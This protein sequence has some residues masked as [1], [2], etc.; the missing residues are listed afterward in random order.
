MRKI[1]L[2]I[3]VGCLFLLSAAPALADVCKSDSCSK[4]EVGAFMQDIAAKCYNTG[5]CSLADIMIV[6]NNV[7]IYVLGII[8]SLVLLMYVIGGIMMLT[9]EGGDRKVQGKKM[10]VGATVGMI[11]VFAAYA[12]IITL[13]SVLRNRGLAET[14][15]EQQK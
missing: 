6:I 2:T 4:T 7:G 10:I 11:I 15:S 3:F 14:I 12:A 5:D 1:I 8:G 9:S 13:D